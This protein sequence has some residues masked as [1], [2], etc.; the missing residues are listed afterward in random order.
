MFKPTFYNIFRCS[1]QSFYINITYLRLIKHYNTILYM[2]RKRVSV[3]QAILTNTALNT[4]QNKLK[5]F[6]S[7]ALTKPT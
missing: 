7:Q 5:S 1:L 6:P 2:F 4:M 3:T